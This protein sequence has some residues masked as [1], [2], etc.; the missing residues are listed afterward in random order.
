M[1]LVGFFIQFPLLK[2]IFF[3]E[4]TFVY[5]AFFICLILVAV[6]FKVCIICYFSF[7]SVQKDVLLLASK[8]QALHNLF[9]LIQWSPM[10]VFCDAE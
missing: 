8:M 5:Q 9:I 2:N 4:Q 6:K 1:H 3:S 10:H 7:A